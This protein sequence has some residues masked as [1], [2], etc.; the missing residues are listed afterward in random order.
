[1]KGVQLFDEQKSAKVEDERMKILDGLTDGIQDD[2]FVPPVSCTARF[3][4]PCGFEM[5]SLLLLS[6]FISTQKYAAFY[7][8]LFPTFVEAY[9]KAGVSALVSFESHF[10]SFVKMTHELGGTR[11]IEEVLMT[12][13]DLARCPE[14]VISAVNGMRILELA[15]M[16]PIVRRIMSPGAIIES[17]STTLE[18]GPFIFVADEGQFKFKLPRFVKASTAYGVTGKM[19]D[20]LDQQFVHM[21]SLF[22]IG[23]HYALGLFCRRPVYLLNG[24]TTSVA[25]DGPVIACGYYHDAFV[26]TEWDGNDGGTVREKPEPKLIIAKPLP[27]IFK[28]LALGGIA[29]M[30]Y[31]HGRKESETDAHMISR[32]KTLLECLMRRPSTFVY[33]ES[34]EER[35]EIMIPVLAM[36]L[37]DLAAKKAVAINKQASKLV[38]AADVEVYR[39]KYIDYTRLVFFTTKC[40]QQMKKGDLENALKFARNA[41]AS[42]SSSIF[43]VLALPL[44]AYLHCVRELTEDFSESRMHDGPYLETLVLFCDLKNTNIMLPEHAMLEASPDLARLKYPMC[45]PH[46]EIA[47]GNCRMDDLMMEL[48]GHIDTIADDI[49]ELLAVKESWTG[50]SKHFLE[51][52]SQAQA[53]SFLSDQCF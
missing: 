43:E 22:K 38:T 45:F 48:F 39:C 2:W 49:L 3:R 37:Y 5:Y 11:R 9:E 50:Q 53:R 19:T 1:M 51:Y 30:S 16:R 24:V 23:N 33:K 47:A 31:W 40:L 41:L 21:W 27:Y 13:N 42:A 46:A 52:Q 6:H 32:Y 4:L 7:Q 14:N 25:P 34:G 44:A 15:G 20:E 35:W 36:Q 17:I 12:A 8:Q 28:V 10:E 18:P 26:K 29:D